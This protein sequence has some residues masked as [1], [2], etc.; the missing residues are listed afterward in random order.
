MKPK[1]DETQNTKFSC[2]EYNLLI[3]HTT[4]EIFTFEKWPRPLSAK[5]KMDFHVSL[6]FHGKDYRNP[7]T[8]THG[9]CDTSTEKDKLDSRVGPAEAEADGYVGDGVASLKAYITWMRTCLG[10]Y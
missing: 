10:F 4:F 1:A 2:E 3:C 7:K 8:E 9:P 6:G 5:T